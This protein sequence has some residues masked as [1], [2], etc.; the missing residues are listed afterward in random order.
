MRI[1]G[2]H[3]ATLVLAIVVGLVVLIVWRDRSV[4]GDGIDTAV[5]NARVP[6]VTEDPDNIPI[7]ELETYDLHVGTI[8]NTGFSF[9]EV[10]IFNK[11]KAPLEITDVQ[12]NCACTVGGVEKQY[13]PIPPGGEGIL[14]IRLEP[15]RMP[16][17]NS[18][19][20][21]T[22]QSNDAIHP[23]VTLHVETDVEPEY[24]L[25]PPELDMGRMA[26]GDGSTATMILRQLRDE[27]IEITEVKAVSYTHLTLPTN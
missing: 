3:I 8:P 26:K 22:I 9:A 23:N 14:K 1:R 17:F 2:S 21:L 6:P 15:R 10:K 4:A 12:T 11:G 13:N 7:I 24:E 25:I 5:E 16:G 27:P 18:R 20:T 19:K